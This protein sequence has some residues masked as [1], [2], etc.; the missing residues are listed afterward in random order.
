MKNRLIRWTV[1]AVISLSVICILPEMAAGCLYDKCYTTRYGSIHYDSTILIMEVHGYSLDVEAGDAL[2]IRACNTDMSFDPKLELFAPQGNIIVTAGIPGTGLAEFTTKPI[3]QPGNY[4][5]AVSDIMGNGRGDY[6]LTVQ[7]TNRPGNAR[8]IAFDQMIR[9]TLNIPSEMGVFQFDA[10]AGETVSI[11][12]IGINPKLE[13]HLRLF[14]PNGGFIAG[15]LDYD[16]AVIANRVLPL[17]GK[18]TI[19]TNDDVGDDQGEYF[20][21]LSRVPTAADDEN[22]ARLPDAFELYQNY[23]NPFNAETSISF[24]LLKSSFVELHIYNIIGENVRTLVS[25]KM[26]A[27][28]HT[29]LWDGRDASGQEAP[30]GIYFYRLVADEFVATKKMLLLK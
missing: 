7:S 21:I 1:A 5:I 29:V 28:R 18:Y 3:I 17:D 25:R 24:G 11:Q 6:Y 2:I 13:P 4:T 30:S 8:P 9:D 10:V 27:G 22:P 12:M 14:G 15:D 23:P 16:Y 19:F 26:S 20:L